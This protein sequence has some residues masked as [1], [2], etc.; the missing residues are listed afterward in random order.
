MMHTAAIA[1][2]SVPVGR[3]ANVGLP[4]YADDRS[5]RAEALLRGARRGRAAPVRDG[6]GRGHAHVGTTGAGLLRAPPNRH[7]RQPRRGPVGDG[8]RPLR[9]HRHGGRR[10]RP[11]RWARARHLPPPGRLHGGRDRPGD[12]PGGTGPGANAHAGGHLAC[13]A[14]PGPA[15]SARCGARA[16]RSRRERSAWTS[17]CCSISPRSSSRTPTP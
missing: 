13:G 16:C 5:Q 14:A 8:R 11:G 17:S 9:D 6:P 15:S 10:A 3:P 12:G 7:F 4:A 1:A 2:P